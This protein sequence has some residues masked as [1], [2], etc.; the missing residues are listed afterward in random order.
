MQL[1]SFSKIVLQH[2]HKNTK[3][4]R[5][6]Y[7]SCHFQDAL[8]FRELER[9]AFMN[10][11]TI[12]L[13][14]ECNS[15]CK[16][17]T[18]SIEQVLP[19]I[20]DEKLKSIIMNYNDKHI[21]IGDEC[22]QMLKESLEEEQDPPVMAK[23]FSWISTEMKLIINNDTHKIADLMIDGCNM[24]IKS[25]SEYINKYNFSS[26]ESKHLAKKLVGMEQEFMNELLEYL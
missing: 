14:K 17:A 4:N 18:N 15:G 7:G 22:H 13:L 16:M 2:N 24:G 19:N 25:V 6:Q 9:M 12:N 20:T 1:R 23:A 11:D 26:E 8:F 10:Q 21:K 3:K 5:G